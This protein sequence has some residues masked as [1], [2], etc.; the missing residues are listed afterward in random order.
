MLMTPGKHHKTAE[1]K[2]GHTKICSF[3][4]QSDQTGTKTNTEFQDRYAK[5]T[6]GNHM[7]QLV[8]NNQKINGENSFD[9]VKKICHGLSL[10]GRFGFWGLSSETPAMVFECAMAS[11]QAICRGTRQE[12]RQGRKDEG[13]EK[14]Y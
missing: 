2:R 10:T 9:Q 7:S 5:Q 8:D 3:I 12:K 1:G 6:S 13:E 14:N 4:I 11:L